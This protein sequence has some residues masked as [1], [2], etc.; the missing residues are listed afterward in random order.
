MMMKNKNKK[1]FPAPMAKSLSNPCFRPK[2]ICPKNKYDRRRL[3]NDLR[4]F[5]QH[6]R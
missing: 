4:R 6:E 5:C 1:V 3:K 2:V